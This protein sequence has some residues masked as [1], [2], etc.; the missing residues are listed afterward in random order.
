FG[1]N[2]L[3]VF[4]D[5]RGLDDGTMQAIAREMNLSETTFVLPATR[6]DCAARVRIFT[7]A[8]EI[9]FAGHPT[10]GT[11]WV[12]ATRGRL[13]A[14]GGAREE[15]IGP[16]PVE[17]E[18]DPARPTFVWMRHRDAEF[19]PEVTDRAGVAAAL[20]L[21]AD[22]LRPGAPVRVG[23]T[24]SSFLYVPLVD[25]AAVDRAALDVTAMR[26]A[27]G[28]PLPGVFV[29]AAEAG[30]AY[31]RM[32]APHTSRIAEDPATG[33]A[34]GPLGAYLVQY[35]LAGTEGA[36]RLVSEQGTQMGRQ[37]FVHIRV[38][39][40]GGRASD[41]AVGGSVVPVLEGRLALPER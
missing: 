26:R 13:G 37:S 16:V 35:G 8:R 39:A 6:P 36:L 40:A 30:G 33:S 38:R 20:G 18:G 2:P 7:P 14:A 10:V 27:T 3:A 32:F 12:L 1:G 24:G 29:F 11:A 23:S 9:P 15:G 21:P 28:E 17:L 5:G 19:G 41:L 34:S 31:S 22:A 25:R 4:L